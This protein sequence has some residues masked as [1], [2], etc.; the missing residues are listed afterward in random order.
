[1]R[2]PL[3]LLALLFTGTLVARADS[4]VVVTING[5]VHYGDDSF[6]TSFSFDPA[7][8]YT[9]PSLDFSDD[10]FYTLTMQ[11]EFSAPVHPTSVQFE[12]SAATWNEPNSFLLHDPSQADFDVLIAFVPGSCLD[13]PSSS[14]GGAIP[15]FTS[16]TCD[17]IAD[18][19]S[20]SDEPNEVITH[21]D[22]VEFAVEGASQVPEPSSLALIGTGLLGVLHLGSRSLHARRR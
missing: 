8:L 9:S 3:L 19:W 10:F 2:S 22:S 1:M 5:F 6:S 7:T 17:Q 18:F 21:I 12:G 15:V 4:L 13:L 16:K 11:P 20:N 14:S